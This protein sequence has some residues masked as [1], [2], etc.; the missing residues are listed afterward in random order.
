M[1]FFFF[2]FVFS[3]LFCFPML[4]I[5]ISHSI[6][7]I[8]F[9]ISAPLDILLYFIIIIIQSTLILISTRIIFFVVVVVDSHAH[10]H[11]PLTWKKSLIFRLVQNANSSYLLSIISFISFLPLKITFSLS[12]FSFPARCS[13]QLKNLNQILNWKKLVKDLI[14]FK[15]FKRI[16]KIIKQFQ[17]S[18]SFELE[19]A[20]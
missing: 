6:H 8:K 16:T 17:F 11:T 13:V 9:I 1:L 3:L 2:L 12:Q 5:I 15:R 19:H 14:E 18:G 10:K 4:I 20:T 7:I